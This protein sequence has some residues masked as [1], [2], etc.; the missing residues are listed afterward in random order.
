M[1]HK[2]VSKR[3]AKKSKSDSNDNINH[4]SSN[5]HPGE[6]SL[7]SVQSLMKDKVAPLNR[8]DTKASNKGNN[9]N[10]KGK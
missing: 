10:R 5:A 9:K 2:G 4:G 7:P 6:C 3:K 8:S 1:G